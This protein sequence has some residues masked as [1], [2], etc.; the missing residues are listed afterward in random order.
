VQNPPDGY[1]PAGQE[2]HPDD[3]VFEHVAQEEWQ[4]WQI[5]FTFIW[6]SKQSAKQVFVIVS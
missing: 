1:F 4:F 3:E 5:P 6:L 2:L